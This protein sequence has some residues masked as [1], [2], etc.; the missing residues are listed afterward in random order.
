[1]V[2]ECI[3]TLRFGSKTSEAYFHNPSVPDFLRLAAALPT[4]LRKLCSLEFSGISDI[5]DCNTILNLG[6]LESVASITFNKCRLSADELTALVSAFPRL[7][8][9]RIE[10]CT[11]VFLGRLKA[12]GLP[13]VHV[14][15]L[16]SLSIVSKEWVNDGLQTLFNHLLNTPCVRTLRSLKLVIGSNDIQPVGEFL[17]A[18]GTNLESLEL[19]FVLELSALVEICTSTYFCPY[20]PYS[21]LMVLDRNRPIH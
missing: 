13:H 19:G 3:Q 9:V 6:A 10:H 16:K 20:D 15:R 8:D 18:L 2:S 17:W 14:P 12:R 1:M 21:W 5:W 7:Q 11:D 4:P